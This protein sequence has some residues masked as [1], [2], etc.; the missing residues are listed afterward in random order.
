MVSLSQGIRKLV[1]TWINGGLIRAR[2]I[3]LKGGTV[4][5]RGVVRRG[6]VSSGALSSSG[7]EAVVQGGE[8]AHVKRGFWYLVHPVALFAVELR[9]PR[10]LVCSAYVEEHV[11]TLGDKVF[12]AVYRHNV[13]VIKGVPSVADWIEALSYVVTSHH[14]AMVIAH[15]IQ[16]IQVLVSVR[17][18]VTFR[19]TRKTTFLR[20]F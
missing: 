19:F 10:G 17:Q 16:V 12:H 20:F 8:L 18:Q 5:R 14:V 9:L 7:E 3:M 11:S 6:V 15:C 1:G 13:M 2:V 4:V